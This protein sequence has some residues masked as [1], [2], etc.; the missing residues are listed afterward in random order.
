MIEV[1]KVNQVNASKVILKPHE[2]LIFNKFAVGKN[3]EKDLRITDKNNNTLL[4]ENT[5]PAII[6]APLL[7]NIADSAIVE[8]SWV[9]NRL[10]FEEEKLED[11]AVKMERWF[12]VKI[13]INNESI[14]SYRLTGSFQDE[15]T[16]EALKE[17]QYLVSFSYKMT[18]KEVLINKK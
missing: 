12:N 15:T 2:K 5:G 16:D 7:K 6:I 18:G 8:T 11:L 13:K 17:L 4:F 9:Y 14:K 3:A 1:T 10:S